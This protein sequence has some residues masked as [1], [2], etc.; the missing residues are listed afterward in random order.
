MVEIRTFNLAVLVF[1][2]KANCTDVCLRAVKF[3]IESPTLLTTRKL[4]VCTH[5][6]R[7]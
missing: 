5:K 4:Q 7:L 2:E 1:F 6:M 3:L